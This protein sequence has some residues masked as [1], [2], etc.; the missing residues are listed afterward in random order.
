M[1][2]RYFRSFSPAIVLILLGLAYAFPAQAAIPVGYVSTDFGSREGIRAMAVQP[3]GKIIAAGYQYGPSGFALSRYNPNGT[4]DTTFGSGG[5]VITTYFFG[6]T[7]DESSEAFAL[8]LQPDGKIVLAGYTQKA[9]FAVARYN[10]DGSLDATFG[11]GGQVATDLG[12]PYD[13]AYALAFQPDGKIVVG[14]FT[15]PDSPDFAMVRYHVN[16]DLDSSF[17]VG[18]I[19]ITDLDSGSDDRITALTVQADG[20]ILAAGRSALRGLGGFGGYDMAIARYNPNGTL[21]TTFDV[22]G[23]IKADLG[24]RFDEIRAMTLLADGKIMAAGSGGIDSDIALARFNANGSLDTRF[25]NNG[26]VITPSATSSFDQAT[27][28]YTQADG[29]FMV[30]AVTNGVGALLRYT[31]RGS[32]SNSFSVGGIATSVVAT[33]GTYDMGLALQADGKP[34]LGGILRGVGDNFGLARFNTNGTLDTTFGPQADVSVSISATPASLKITNHVTYTITV[35][36]SGPDTV[37]GVPVYGVPVGA[38]LV[39]ASATSGSCDANGACTLGSLPSGSSATVTVVAATMVLG[40]LTNTVTVNSTSADPNAANNTASVDV[41][42]DGNADLSVSASVTPATAKYGDSLTY[43][44]TVT[45]HGPDASANA[46]LQVGFNLGQVLSFTS[47]AGSCSQ[48]AYPSCSFGVIASGSSVVVTLVL[49]VYQNGDY[50]V[51]AT[52]ISLND[53]NPANNNASASAAANTVYDLAVSMTADQASLPVGQNFTYRINVKNLG[54]DTGIYDYVSIGFGYPH[55]NSVVSVSTTRGSCYVHPIQVNCDLA[56][57]PSGGSVDITLVVATPRVPGSFAVSAVISASSSDLNRSND[58]ASLTSTITGQT[59]LV[60]SVTDSPDP[61][62][63]G[64]SLTY[65]VTL[66]NIGPDAAG[67][68]FL[69]GSIA[70]GMSIQSIAASQGACYASSFA[71]DCPW[72]GTINSGAS[73]TITIVALP[74]S[75]GTLNSTFT[76]S[77]AGLN[78]PNTANNSATASTTV[79]GSADLAVSITDSPDPIRV[80]KNLTYQITLTNYGVS[81]ADLTTLSDTLPAGVSFVSATSTQGSCLNNLGTVTCDFGTLNAYTTA[82]VDIVVTVNVKRTTLTNTVSV[83]SSVVDPNTANNSA[84]ALTTVQ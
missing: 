17:G 61:V 53:A 46:A 84:T 74:Y 30:S 1:Q 44:M 18:G 6:A 54:P 47:S 27:N 71:I 59:D 77:S 66:T 49:R 23:K 62:R 64:D 32:L 43:T 52:A 57:L 51:S 79:T 9:D 45:N 19:V 63:A 70:T 55:P 4:L 21:D 76:A 12:D 29:N 31:S 82:T 67:D 2:N 65:T 26:F 10:T 56:D 42:V 72:F 34:V 75:A 36:N 5:K 33:T 68:V 11:V 48:T 38:T 69:A 8:G 41:L 80:G 60:V 24:G 58:T 25:G 83:S 73:V 37:E 15:I 13:L 35:T 39:S 28:I 16:G 20:L 7:V 3:D 81:S 78:D 50:V 40:T 14:G 22:D